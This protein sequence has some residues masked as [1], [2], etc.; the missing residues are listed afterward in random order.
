MDTIIGIDLGTTNSAVGIMEAGLPFLLADADGERLTPS[1]V[2][3]PDDNSTALIGRAASRMRTLRPANTIYSV[4]RLIGAKSGSDL[5]VV[6]YATNMVNGEVQ[7]T[8]NGLTHSPEEISALILAKLKKDAETTLGQTVSKAVITVPAHFNDA[9]RAATKRAGEMA[10]LTVERILNEPTAAALAYGLDKLKDK[11]KIAVYDLGGGTFDISILELNQ[12]VFEV[13]STNGNT[14][15]GGDDLDQALMAEC[16]LPLADWEKREL[17][18]QAKHSLSSN[19]SVEIPIPFSQDGSKTYQLTRSRLEEI[20]R[21]IIEQTRAH[22]VRSLA[23]AKLKPGELDE[24]I[25]VGGST[26]MPLVRELV[27]EWFGK[28]PNITQNPD[29]AVALGATIQ[30]GILS[31]SVTNITLLD[32]TPLSLGIETAGGLMN[33]LI[34][35]NST[36]PL[37]R[38]EMFTTSANNQTSMVIKVLQGEREMA[39]DNWNLGE[40]T[41]DFAAAPRGVARV[42]VQFEIDANGILH[43]LARDVATGTDRVLALSSNVNVA[44]EKVEQMIAESVEHAFD[45]MSERIFTEASLKAK[46]MLAAVDNALQLLGDEMTLEE[47]Q[48]IELLTKEV[49]EA[50]AQGESQRLKRANLA[51][52]QGTQNLATLLMEKAMSEALS[53]RGMI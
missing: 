3:F 48:S 4:K 15:L 53:K 26:R 2:Y 27:K 44:D 9:Q 52:D 49:S 39:R 30:A 33:V 46:E 7:V 18:I 21:P 12:G 37:K 31:G 29:E 34:P 17:V 35:R 10:G 40:F 1:V 14:Q 28:E 13:L 47:K 5:P 16:H 22:C 25:L 51:L 50:I 11:S 20:C 36:I 23:D 42:G 43:V 45:D 32:V 19:E 41:I 38:G 8:V 6:S 24:V